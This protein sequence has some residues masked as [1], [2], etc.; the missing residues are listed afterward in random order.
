MLVPPKLTLGSVARVVAPARSLSIIS[1]ETKEI[2][3]A[4]FK[5]L[6][7][8]V[9]FGKNV[10]VVDDVLSSPP[11]L[12]IED[13]HD[14][15]SN[16]DVNCIFTVIGGFNSIQIIDGLDYDLIASNPKIICGYSDITVLVNAIHA[17]T[18]LITYYG[19]HYSSLG[20]LKGGEYTVEYLKKSLF[21]DESF[22]VKPSE[23]WSDDTWFLDQENRTFKPNP[24][25]IIIREGETEGR[26]VGGNINA[27][28]LLNGTKYAPELSGRMLFLENDGLDK[29][30]TDREFDRRLDSLLLQKGGDEIV[31]LIIGRFKELSK[32]N[33]EVL[34]RI[35]L[36]KEKLRNIPIVYGFDFGHSNPILTLPIGGLAYLKA[37]NGEII[38][39]IKEH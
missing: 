17:K 14:A 9:T 12:R 38:F 2:A 18:N 19:P 35:V 28:R 15:F 31:G 7:I 6:G 13:L 8:D 30:I 26:L 32:M 29:E 25:P 20:M 36:S 27:F 23:F 4:N 3:N 1:E 37:V 21:S 11:H 16:T 33:I 24:E 39:E 22:L 5:E 34:R 10:E